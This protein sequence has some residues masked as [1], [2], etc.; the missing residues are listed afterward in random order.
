L[1]YLHKER[2]YLYRCTEISNQIYDEFTENVKGERKKLKKDEIVEDFKNVFTTNLDL[3]MKKYKEVTQRYI[4]SIVEEVEEVLK[5]RICG[6]IESLFEKQA[7]LM[8]KKIRKRTKNDFTLIRNEYAL[9]HSKKEY[10]PSKYDKYSKKLA[11]TKSVIERDWK[12]QF[13]ASV[14]KFLA[15][16]TKNKVLQEGEEGL[17][18]RQKND[19]IKTDYCL[20]NH[21]RLIRIR[22]WESVKAILDL[23]NLK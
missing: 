22:Y 18:R 6:F 16:S 9:L 19:K 3:S 4:E 5:K 12:N 23:Y 15:E 20:K 8:E 14:P 21:I 1:I 7:E 11:T 10:I 2:C 17:K 13:D